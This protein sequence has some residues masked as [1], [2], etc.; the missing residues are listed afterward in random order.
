MP[1]KRRASSPAPCRSRATTPMA[2]SRPSPACTAWC[3]SRPMTSNA[4][5]HTS[6]SSVWVYPVVDDN[7]D[8]DDRRQRPEGRHL[9]RL[10]RRR[11]ARQHHRLRRAHHPHAHR[12]HRRLPGRALAAQEPRHRDEDA[13]GPPLRDGTAEAAGKDRRRQRQEDRH[14]LGPPDP[15]LR[16]AALPAGQGPAHRPHLD[17]R[18]ATCS[19]AKSRTSSRPRSP[20][21]SRAA[22][23]R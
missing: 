19:T 10:G 2:S 21:R 7:I 8:I 18:R 23:T 6:F 15:L 22:A 20:T 14:R 17:R 4:R 12:H 16:A 11:P 5:R 3:A 1:A 9:P 13:E